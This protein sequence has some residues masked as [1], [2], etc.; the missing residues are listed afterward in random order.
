MNAAI[1]AEGLVKHYGD[2]KALDGLDLEVPEGTVLGVLGPNGAGKTTAVRVLTTL[3]RPD[4]GT[5]TVAGVDVVADPARVRPLIGLSGQYA[6]VDEH[7]TG[8]ENLQ[9]FAQLHRMSARAAKARAEE[10]LGRF[11]LTDAGDRPVKTYSG[12]MRRR[13]D[14]AGALVVS[15][16]VIFLDEPT[17]GLDP[18]SRQDMWEVI[19]EL[20]RGGVSLLL[21]TQYLEEADR[22]AD[23]IVVVDHGKVIAKGSADELKSEIGGETLDVVVATDDQV[24]PAVEALRGIGHGA[25]SV[26]DKTRR[27]SVAVS[28]GAAS[29]V[30][31][32][33][34]FDD[35]G[36]K[37]LDIGLHRPTLDDVFLALT[38]RSAEE[39]EAAAQERSARTRKEGQQ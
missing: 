6:A 26:D 18:R 17:T 5:A 16:Q 14:L 12:G 35:R 39:A 36:V 30:E 34:R 8:R 20:V 38:G 13:L 24:A 1:R 22:L 23:T 9:M 33:R 21:T 37:I 25:P 4:A 19:G 28:G 2:V 32:V 3:L 27:V 29:L 31:A 11:T 7:L 15:P 10:L